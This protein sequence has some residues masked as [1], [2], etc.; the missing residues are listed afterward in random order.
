MK[1]TFFNFTDE[2]F[3]GRFGGHPYLFAP[4]EIQSFDPDKHY[5]LI[6]MAKQLADRELLKKAVTVGKNPNDMEKF[7]KA[8]DEHGN[9][10]TLTVEGRRTLMKKA[11]GDLVDTPVPTPD[12]QEEV[13]STQGTESDIAGLKSQISEM[14]EMIEQLTAASVK[15]PV[16]IVSAPQPHPV[17][18]VPSMDM[19]RD[20]LVEMAQDSGLDVTPEMRKEDIVAL[21]SGTGQTG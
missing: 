2:P 16:T 17:D 14:K 21:L 15:T 8:L 7:G 13:G 18:D 3:T 10:F 1:Y 5:M 19:T 9:I 6:V 11:I 12:I 20:L 4:K